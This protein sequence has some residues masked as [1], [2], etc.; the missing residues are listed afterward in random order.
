MRT[1]ILLFLII[2]ILSLYG[3]SNILEDS[4]SSILL[5]KDKIDGSNLSRTQFVMS[6]D[7]LCIVRHIPYGK[8]DSIIHHLDYIGDLNYNTDQFALEIGN[9]EFILSNELKDILFEF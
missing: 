2:P 6:S 9:K 7:S 8:L 4:V 5:K 3:Q 1:L